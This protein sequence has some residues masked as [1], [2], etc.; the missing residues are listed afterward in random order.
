MPGL[1]FNVSWGE[2]VFT[3]PTPSNLYLASIPENRNLTE[4]YNAVDCSLMIG[5]FA[6]MLH[7]RRIIVTSSKLSRL[8]ACVQ[9]ANTLIYPMFWQHIFI[10]VLPQHLMD[11]LSAPMPFLIGVPQPLLARAKMTELGDVV[12]LY[13]DSHTMESPYNDVENIPSDVIHNLKKSLAPNKDL[14]GDAVAKAFLQALVHLIGGYREALKY[15]QGEKVSF[16]DEEFIKSRSSSLQ[17]F[18]EQMLQLQIFRQFID[19]RLELLNAGKGFSDQFELECVAFSEERSSRKYKP[20]A[21]INNVKREGAAFAKAVKEKANP[22]MKHAVKTVKDSS[23]IAKSK[24]KASYK[25]MKS[26]MKDD[27]E[28]IKNEPGNT[29]SAPSSPTLRRV[30]N[31]SSPQTSFLTRNNTD[32]NFGRVLKYEKFDPPDRKDLSPEFEEI[33]KLEYVDLMSSL[34]EVISRNKSENYSR[35]QGDSLASS[36]SSSLQT[37]NYNRNVE[38]SVRDPIGDLITLADSD[39]VVFDPLLE[40]Q[41][42]DF[43]QNPHR[44][45]E[46]TSQVNGGLRRYSQGKY[47]N[48]V[49]AGGASHREFKQ[50]VGTMTEDGSQGGQ[51]R[52]SDDLLSEYGINFNSMSV[53]RGVLHNSQPHTVLAGPPPVPPRSVN[54]S[55]LHTTANPFLQ[56]QYNII[57]SPLNNRISSVAPH[58]TDILADLDPLRTGQVQEPGQASSHLAA[59]VVPPRTKKQWTTFE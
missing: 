45:L 13:A 11:Y 26:R 43:P 9:A 5:I 53:A 56:N 14:L 6:S 34:E 2:S 58:S 32:L 41:R 44:K 24:A 50:F 29:H 33:P 28:E 16:S 51:T 27:K 7:E 23:K 40:N 52:C 46:R 10:P 31:I 12:I 20:S 4:Y 57:T 36:S 48:H 22:A 1:V 30:S 8:S 17:P 18:L 54:T 21:T 39:S 55:F 49:P 37:N 42:L 25:D 59:P 3:G 38:N 35:L 19:E 15:R 47:E